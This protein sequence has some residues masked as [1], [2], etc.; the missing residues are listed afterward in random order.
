MDLESSHFKVKRAKQQIGEFQS[1]CG[2]M[3]DAK[4]YSIVPEAH[5]DPEMVSYRIRFNRGF[6]MP[7]I[8]SNIAERFSTTPAQAL[9]HLAYAIVPTPTTNT[10]FP[11]WRA[12][13]VPT[14]QDLEALAG[15]K[16]KGTPQPMI[17]WIAALQSYLGGQHQLLWELDHL[18]IVDKHRLLVMMFF[19]FQFT[20]VGK[21]GVPDRSG[22]VEHL[23]RL[24]L[25]RGTGAQ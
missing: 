13:R 15:G 20:M 19:D 2:V 1:V 24:H 22:A 18:N 6:R 8:L 7:R 10:A 14:P 21:P 23:H 9:D 11:I 4:P 3:L 16:V 25:G 5:D 17:D 12:E